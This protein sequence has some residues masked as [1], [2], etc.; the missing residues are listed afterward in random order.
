MQVYDMATRLTNLES[1]TA[2]G[3]LELVRRYCT[4]L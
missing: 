4:L 3:T 1:E 2:G